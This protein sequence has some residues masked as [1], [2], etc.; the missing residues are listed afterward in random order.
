MM[1]RNVCNKNELTFA[2]TVKWR[3]LFDA[4]FFV[5]FGFLDIPNVYRHTS[6]YKVVLA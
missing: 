6:K 1:E 5:E 4:Y 2:V 3:I